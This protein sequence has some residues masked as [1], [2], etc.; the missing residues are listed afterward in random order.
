MGQKQAFQER[1]LQE[2]VEESGPGTGPPGEDG[3]GTGPVGEDGGGWA[4]NRPSRRRWR[5]VGQEQALQEKIE[6]G[7]GT[8]P[9]EELLDQHSG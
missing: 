9:L 1:G 2:K 4:R 7:P 5:R 3:S 6:N 8:G